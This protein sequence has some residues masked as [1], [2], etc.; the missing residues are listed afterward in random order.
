MQKGLG[1]LLMRGGQAG[2]AGSWKCLV[3]PLLEGV[4]KELSENGR[5]WLG[6]IFHRHCLDRPPLRLPPSSSK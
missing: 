5:V 2:R 3:P 6:K 4:D 1:Y